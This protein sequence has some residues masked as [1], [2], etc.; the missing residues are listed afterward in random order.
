MRCELE[1]CANKEADKHERIRVTE[2]IW[3]SSYNV[4]ICSV[5]ANKLGMKQDQI[6][7]N[8]VEVESILKR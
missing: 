2:N 8:A 7:K 6:L 1:H 4:Y 3:D 5:C